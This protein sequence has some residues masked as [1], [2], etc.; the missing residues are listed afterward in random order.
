M[1]NILTPTGIL[2]YKSDPDHLGLVLHSV[3]LRQSTTRLPLFQI[4]ATLG[5]SSDHPCFLPMGYSSKI[6]FIISLQVI[7]HQNDSQISGKCCAYNYSFITKPTNQD[8]SNKETHK[9]RPGRVLNAEFAHPLPMESVCIITPAHPCLHQQGSSTKLLHPEFLL[10]F[11]F[12]G[13]ID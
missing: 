7:I 5:E 8:E 3:G 4:P 9:S 1:A 12:A 11:Y 13:I 6:M 10:G 2:Q